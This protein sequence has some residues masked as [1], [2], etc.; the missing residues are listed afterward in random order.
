MKMNIHNRIPI[1]V[2]ICFGSDRDFGEADTVA[3]CSSLN[4]LCKSS[5]LIKKNVCHVANGILASYGMCCAAGT[6]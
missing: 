1:T 3:K 2:N 5:Q 6:V 4:L